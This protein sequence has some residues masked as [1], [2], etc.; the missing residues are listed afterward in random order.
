MDNRCCALSNDALERLKQIEHTAYSDNP[1]LTALQDCNNWQD[2]ALYCDCEVKDLRVYLFAHGYMLCA[3]H[4]TELEIV[5]LASDGKWIDLRS[6]L[7]ILESYDKPLVMYCRETTSYPIL[8]YMEMIG[9]IVISGDIA[10]TYEEEQFH[11][12]RAYTNAALSRETVSK[13]SREQEY[14]QEEE[15]L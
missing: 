6:V 7:H 12:V 15:R 11:E 1:E 4:V 3:E 9:R 10:E 8:K 2:V 14:S 13:Y 5:D